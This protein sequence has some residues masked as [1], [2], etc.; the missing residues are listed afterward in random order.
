MNP[1]IFNVFCLIGGIIMDPILK[2]RMIIADQKKEWRVIFTNVDFTVLCQ[3]NTSK[4]ILNK[5][6]TDSILRSLG[7]QEL[8]VIQ[9]QQIIIDKSKMS[10]I[11]TKKFNINTMIVNRVDEQYAPTYL[12]LSGR[13]QYNFITELVETTGYSRVTVL[14]VIRQYLQSGMQECSLLDN[15]FYGKMPEKLNFKLKPGHPTVY[16]KFRG[17]IIDENDEKNFINAIA[18]KTRSNGSSRGVTWKDAYIYMLSN[19]YQITIKNK[20]GSI[21]RALLPDDQIPTFK[22]FYYYAHKNTN[23]VDIDIAQTSEFEVQNDKR[24]L[25]GSAKTNVFGPGDVFEIDA[26]EVDVAL[27]SKNDSNQAIGR[28]ILYLMIDVYTGMI[29]AVSVALDNNSI[30]GLTN[31]IVNLS[32]NKHELCKKYG[33]SLKEDSIWPTGYKPNAFRVDH[34]SDFIS[35]QFHRIAE[36]LGIE[37]STV[38]IKNGSMKG[39]VEHTFRTLQERIGIPLI[40]KGKI[41]KRYDSKHHKQAV[42]NIDDFKKIVL[43]YVIFHNTNYIPTRPKS[44]DQI[45][46]DIPS[47]PYRLWDYYCQTI[48]TP[49]LLPSKEQL[50]YTL[51]IPA[52]ASI[53]ARQ[54]GITLEGLHYSST[55]EKIEMLRYELQGKRIKIDIRYDPRDVSK[56]YYLDRYNTLQTFELNMRIPE[57]RSYVGMTWECYRSIRKKGKDMD[58]QNESNQIQNRIYLSEGVKSVVKE[59]SIDRDESKNNTKGMTNARKIE[60]EQISNSNNFGTKMPKSKKLESVIDVPLKEIN[61]YEQICSKQDVERDLSFLEGLDEDGKKIALAALEY[62]YDD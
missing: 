39:T 10:E 61:E 25:S 2:M 7:R 47:I 17:K 59:A 9:E 44:K 29:M 34:G 31:V 52:K 18:M 8:F 15:R 45:D 21:T 33:I 56:I 51:M 4:L 3:I 62:I 24:L 55:L 1:N 41:E 50:L 57:N 42:L 48:K 13:K 20:D 40:Q 27:V 30:V 58:K 11:I 46:N 60:K 35:K 43:E 12:E 37:I 53:S 32:E 54:P 28:P 19:N 36:E 26:C 14:K 23:K 16:G 38:P 5:V 49:R 22:Q 6:K